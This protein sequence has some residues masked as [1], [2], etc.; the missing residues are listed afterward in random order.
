MSEQSGLVSA[1]KWGKG[2][3]GHR[4]CACVSRRVAT[5]FCHPHLIRD[6]CLA[7]R[8]F[9]FSFLAFFSRASFT[10]AI[11]SSSASSPAGIIKTPP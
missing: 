1:I 10:A 6:F 5:T 2:R 4:L 3:G 7:S 11:S 8:A 9:F